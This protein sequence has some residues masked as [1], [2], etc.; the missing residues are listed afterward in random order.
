MRLN[1]NFL[2]DKLA[3]CKCPTDDQP[4]GFPKHYLALN[5]GIIKHPGCLLRVHNELASVR[6]NILEC[7]SDTFG[8]ITMESEVSPST[9]I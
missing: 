3:L 5:Y 8:V 2:D 6:F 4:D 7:N 9:R 1:I